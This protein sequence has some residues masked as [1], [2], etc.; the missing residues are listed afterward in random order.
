MKPWGSGA[1]S[2]PPAHA[3]PWHRLGAGGAPTSASQTE[4]SRRSEKRADR[5]LDAF[6]V[7]SASD[8]PQAENDAL[9]GCAGL[10]PRG[11]T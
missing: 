4:A 6:A 9:G 3:A 2:D 1:L 5:P 7:E 8:L 11:T 10:Q